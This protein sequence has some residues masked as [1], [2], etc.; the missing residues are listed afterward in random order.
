MR[1]WRERA[2]QEAR[3]RLE[4]DERV[5][6]WATTTADETIVATQRGLLLPE[7][8][9]LP[10]HEID[11]AGWAEG[12]LTLTPARIADG[13]IDE[14]PDRRYVL[15][16]PRKLPQ[17]VRVRVTRSVAFT[18]HVELE[19]AGGVRIVA[20]KVSGRDGVLW[21]VRYDAGTDRSDP[22]VRHQVEAYLA[23]ARNRFTPPE[24]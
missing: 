14:L 24:V 1:L 10:W 6:S 7:P 12:V 18:E 4:R 13:V 23:E 16:V 15:A 19:P 5:L 8:E 22:F 11:R 9:R 2:P 21:A 3:R 17:T 20:R